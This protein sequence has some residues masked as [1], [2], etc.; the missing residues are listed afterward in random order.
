MPT[1][2]C[3]HIP[4]SAVHA[5]QVQACLMETLLELGIAGLCESQL[6]PELTTALPP[7]LS[8]VV[9]SGLNRLV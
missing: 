7:R 3:V 5:T 4:Q 1:M 6:R 2:A 8:P 9:S